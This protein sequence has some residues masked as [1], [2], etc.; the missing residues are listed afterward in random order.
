MPGTDISPT[1]SSTSSTHT[2]YGLRH[3]LRIRYAMSGT[4]LADTALPGFQEQ[5]ENRP[6]ATIQADPY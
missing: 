1:V 5:A 2:W 6:I 4:D 3:Q